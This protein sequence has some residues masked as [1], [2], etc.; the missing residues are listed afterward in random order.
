MKPSENPLA[1]N[2]ERIARAYA[3]LFGIFDVPQPEKALTPSELR[4]AR[5][6]ARANRATRRWGHQR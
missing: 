5:G 4:E 6:H 3:E 1:Y 2:F